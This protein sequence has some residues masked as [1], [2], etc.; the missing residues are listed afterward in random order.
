[1]STRSLHSMAQ[2]WHRRRRS[3]VSGSVS[4][5][6]SAFLRF[7]DHLVPLFQAPMIR[8][9]VAG[10]DGSKSDSEAGLLSNFPIG[11][12]MMQNVGNI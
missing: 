12:K 5:S 8:I 7:E 10:W 9:V 3:T 2:P 1:M 6:V 11:T 4:G